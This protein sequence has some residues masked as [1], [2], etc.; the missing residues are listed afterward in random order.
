MSIGVKHYAEKHIRERGQEVHICAQARVIL[1]SQGGTDEVT[2]ELNERG[3][4]RLY[5]KMTA[6]GWGKSKSKNPDKEA[7]LPCL[8]SNRKANMFGAE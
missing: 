1:H 5:L 6:P 3:E 8:K 4:A 2:F 7:Y